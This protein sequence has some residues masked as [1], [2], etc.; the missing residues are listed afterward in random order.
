MDSNYSH[1]KSVADGVRQAQLGYPNCTPQG[2]NEPW[3]SYSTRQNSFDWQK[4][5]NGN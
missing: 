2:H 3:S 1:D 5:Q 4:K